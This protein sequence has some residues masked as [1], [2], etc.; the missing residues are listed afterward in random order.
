LEQER[1]ARAKNIFFGEPGQET[2]FDFLASQNEQE[3]YVFKPSSAIRAHD[4]EFK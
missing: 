2:F 3:S 1:K 4:N